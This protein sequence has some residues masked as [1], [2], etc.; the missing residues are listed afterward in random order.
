MRV[1]KRMILVVDGGHDRLRCSMVS[2]SDTDHFSKALGIAFR[3]H[4][5]TYQLL[6]RFFTS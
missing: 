5:L 3:K 1:T 6:L 2:W 4:L